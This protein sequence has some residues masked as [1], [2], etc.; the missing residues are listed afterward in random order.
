MRKFIIAIQ[1]AL[2]ALLAITGALAGPDTRPAC[3]L[4]DQVTAA[5]T[6]EK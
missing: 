1:V 4:G 2:I 5:Q 6:C 3:P